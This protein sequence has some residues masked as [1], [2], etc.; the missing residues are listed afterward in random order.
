ML[1]ESILGEKRAPPDTKHSDIWQDRN[2]AAKDSIRR[3]H[4]QFR[5]D[6]HAL[7]F[8]RRAAGEIVR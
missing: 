4:R 6:G 7:A 2:P 3:K 5:K 8:E 1:H